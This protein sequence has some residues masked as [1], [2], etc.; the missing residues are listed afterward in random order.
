MFIKRGFSG[1][2][3]APSIV[4]DPS[5]NNCLSWYENMHIMLKPLAKTDT[6]ISLT[7]RTVS[8]YL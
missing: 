7:T 3:F 2:H 8:W 6:F 5:H 1:K 4:P